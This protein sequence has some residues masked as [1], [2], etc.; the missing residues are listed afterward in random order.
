[1]HSGLRESKCSP[2]Y[3]HETQPIAWSNSLNDEGGRDLHDCICASINSPLKILVKN[4]TIGVAYYL[5]HKYT[6]F[7]TSSG[8]LA[9][10]WITTSQRHSNNPVNEIIHT[11]RRHSWGCFGRDISTGKDLSS[12]TFQCSIL[13]NTYEEAETS[14]TKE[15]CIKLPKKLAFLSRL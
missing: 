3:F 13:G 12:D 5:R 9:Y 14:N 4:M 15:G 8:P 2:T 1:M 11:W 6:R 10:R 7:Q